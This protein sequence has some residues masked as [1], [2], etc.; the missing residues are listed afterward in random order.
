MKHYLHETSN[1]RVVQYE[2]NDYLSY[3]CKKKGNILLF[4]VILLK[5]INGL[6]IEI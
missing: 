6:I 4:N 5:F 2:L 1:G 3:F